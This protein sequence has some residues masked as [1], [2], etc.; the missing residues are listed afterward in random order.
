MQR[1]DASVS[2]L[3][4]PRASLAGGSGPNVVKQLWRPP[5]DFNVEREG[6]GEGGSTLSGFRPQRDGRLAYRPETM[7]APERLQQQQQQQHDYQ[8]MSPQQQQQ[9]QQQNGYQAMS[10]QQ[11]HMQLQQEQL[12]Y[13]QQPSPR[14]FYDEAGL[15]QPIMSANEQLSYDSHQAVLLNDQAKS[16]NFSEQ[17]RLPFHNANNVES[18][19]IGRDSCANQPMSFEM[20]ANPGHRSQNNAQSSING[21]RSMP[22]PG[23]VYC[24]ALGDQ[25]KPPFHH[26]PFETDAYSTHSRAMR[27]TNNDYSTRTLPTHSRRRLT[28]ATEIVSH[29]TVVKTVFLRIQILADIPCGWSGLRYAC[30]LCPP[31]QGTIARSKATQ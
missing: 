11:Q 7:G 4:Y 15:L 16:L 18:D 14:V 2:N 5:A 29:L 12:N 28:A 3:T 31:C 8:T 22:H 9:Q 6:G 1:T 26:R 20:M 10:P 27:S 17:Q 19:P 25:Q 13:N 30:L 21:Q 24:S 23:N